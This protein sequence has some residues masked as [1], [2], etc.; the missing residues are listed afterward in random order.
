MV[1]LELHYLFEIGR[2]TVP[3]EVIVATIQ[4]AASLRLCELS[5]EDVARAA[6]GETWTRDPFDRIIVAQARLREAPLISKDR[7]IRKQYERAIWAHPEP[8]EK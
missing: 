7:T 6:L 5:F 8:V 4:R 3:A 1:L 2:L